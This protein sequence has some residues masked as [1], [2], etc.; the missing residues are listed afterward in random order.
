MT[1][2]AKT[3]YCDRSR[4]FARIFGRI[5]NLYIHAKGKWTKI[6]K[7]CNNCGDHWINGEAYTAPPRRN[8]KVV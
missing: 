7:I 2:G 5:V 6:G 4:G 1:V 8:K 3:H